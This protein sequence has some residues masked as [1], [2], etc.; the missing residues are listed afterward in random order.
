MEGTV[1]YI[2]HASS[3]MVPRRGT[4][5]ARLRAQTALASTDVMISSWRA[6]EMA[7]MQVPARR[8]GV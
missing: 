2:V 1:N 5:A 8:G 4:A 7:A 3:I 6:V